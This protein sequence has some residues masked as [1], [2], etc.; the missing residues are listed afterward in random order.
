VLWDRRPRLSFAGSSAFFRTLVVGALR[1]YKACLSPVLP[2]A[3]R[4]HPTCSDYTRE[5]VERYGV[6][7][8]IW[9]GVRRLARCHPLCAGGLDPVR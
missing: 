5:A 6:A 1:L 9:M 7:R 4:F 2:S 3:C 8:G